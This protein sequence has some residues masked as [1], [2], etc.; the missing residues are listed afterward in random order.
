MPSPQGRYWLLTVPQHLFTPWL[1]PGVLFIKGQLEQG[2]GT[3]YLHWQLLV[4]YGTKVR[5]AAVKT[6][7]GDTVHAELT[8]SAA[9]DEY[10]HKDDTAIA[11]TR[12][13]LGVRAVK[14]N[15]PSDWER[16]WESAKEGRLADIPADLRLQ[17]YRTIK[18]V[19]IIPCPK[20]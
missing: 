19:T 10:V 17:H 8:R 20:P 11:G 15:C 13:E 1:P 14:R 18:Q 6:T 9:A 7:F 5:L 16:I 4:A 12:F 2:N 3:A